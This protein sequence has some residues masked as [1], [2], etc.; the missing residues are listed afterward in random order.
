MKYEIKSWVNGEVLYSCGCG[1]VRKCLRL[2][3]VSRANLTG[4]N[5]TG[6]KNMAKIMGCEA[7][8][9]YWKRFDIGL[10]NNN[11]Q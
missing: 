8:N 10:K 2:A 11:Y 3:V 7:G 6:A 5:L 9:K 1:D 4:A